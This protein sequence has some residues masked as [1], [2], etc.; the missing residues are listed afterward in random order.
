M[1]GGAYG[2]LMGE[3]IGLARATEGNE[4]LISDEST[5]V[6]VECLSALASQNEAV[7]E[8]LLQR[9]D[10]E[11]RRMVP[12]CFQCAAPCGRNN[13]YDLR[14]LQQEEPE[15]RDLKMQ[16]LSSLPALAVRCGA[17][18]AELYYPALIAL[19]IEGID[20]EILRSLLTKIQQK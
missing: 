10:G 12:G 19:G 14:L 17:E 16:L 3:L 9:V 11:K 7:L 1:I 6:I 2:R 13:A 18:A 8:H 4:H 20:P 15:Q 5:A